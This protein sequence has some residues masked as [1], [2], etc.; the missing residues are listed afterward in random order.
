MQINVHA[1]GELRYLC[2]NIRRIFFFAIFYSISCNF[3]LLSS[4][5]PK[6]S[7]GEGKSEVNWKITKKRYEHVKGSRRLS[8]NSWRL[9][10]AAAWGRS[11]WTVLEGR[12]IKLKTF[13]ASLAWI[14]KGYLTLFL[15]TCFAAAKS[16]S[17]AVLTQTSF[18]FISKSSCNHRKQDE[19]QRPNLKTRIIPPTLTT[20][21]EAR[22]FHYNSCHNGTLFCTLDGSKEKLRTSFCECVPEGF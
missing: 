20:E 16:A 18:I 12:K 14:F 1:A 21:K 8:R 9:D 2:R 17:P 7:C 5:P 6:V 3:L 15:P 13:S 10:A 11:S 19:V 4:S 22:K